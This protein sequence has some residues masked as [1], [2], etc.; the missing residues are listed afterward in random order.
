LRSGFGGDLD[1]RPI[2]DS[3][4]NASAEPFPGELVEEAAGI[5]DD[6]LAALPRRLKDDPVLE[7]QGVG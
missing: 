2:A 4:F 7:R 3:I 6:S 1:H 5:P